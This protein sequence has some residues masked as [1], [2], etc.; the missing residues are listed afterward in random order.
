MKAIGPSFAD[1]LKAVGLLGLPFSWGS[2]GDIQFDPRMT[3]AQKDAVLAVYAAHDPTKPVLPLI[4]PLMQA[5][6]TLLAL[7]TPTAQQIVAALRVWRQG[8]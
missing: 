8:M 4:S 6:D 2:N 3:P 7:P 1:E 5:L